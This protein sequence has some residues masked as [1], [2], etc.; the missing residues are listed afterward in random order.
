MPPGA[1]G[2]IFYK[3]NAEKKTGEGGAR[4]GKGHNV[5]IKSECF[6]FALRYM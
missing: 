3:N 5:A 2:L 6:S 4:S 1:A